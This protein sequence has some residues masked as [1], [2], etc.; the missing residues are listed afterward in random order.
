MLVITRPFRY[1][2]IFDDIRKK[3]DFKRDI[4]IVVAIEKHCDLLK[5][6]FNGITK[7]RKCIGKERSRRDDGGE[8]RGIR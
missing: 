2:T 8:I 7:T 5:F 4:A 3:D 1:S 6:V